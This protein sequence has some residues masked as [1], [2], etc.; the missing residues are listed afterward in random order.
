MASVHLAYHH[1]I[2]RSTQKVLK[3]LQLCSTRLHGYVGNCIILYSSSLRIAHWIR[4]IFGSKQSMSLRTPSRRMKTLRVITIWH[5]SCWKGRS[6][7]VAKVCCK[8]APSKLP[9][10]GLLIPLQAPPKQWRIKY[11]NIRGTPPPVFCL[12]SYILNWKRFRAP[13]VYHEA[14]QD[15][16]PTTAKQDLKIVESRRP[17][18]AQKYHSVLY[19]KTSIISIP[20]FWSLTTHLWLTSR[21]TQLCWDNF[22]QLRFVIWSKQD[23]PLRHTPIPWLSTSSMHYVQR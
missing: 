7:G 12:Y 5:H 19:V 14:D 2:L 10:P 16:R 21:K 1:L 23:I 13:Q 17:Q 8:A 9:E 11:W 20:L 3:T 22:N 18:T 6:P 15:K 4:L